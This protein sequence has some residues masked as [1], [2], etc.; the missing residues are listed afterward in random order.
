MK[1]LTFRTAGALHST[2]LG[3][4]CQSSSGAKHRGAEL[5]TLKTISE[6]RRIPFRS[7][8]DGKSRWITQGWPGTLAREDVCSHVSEMPVL[9]PFAKNID[10]SEWLDEC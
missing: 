4:T 6:Y 8:A 5:A 10:P 1:T 9:R 3:M 7:D 2:H